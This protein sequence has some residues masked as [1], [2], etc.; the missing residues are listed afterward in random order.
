M[1][2]KANSVGIWMDHASAHLM[3][4][5]DET[6]E[7]KV[8][9]SKF[10]HEEKELTLTKGEKTMHHREQHDHTAYYKEIASQILQYEKVLLFGPTSAKTELLNLLRADHRFDKIDIETRPADKMTE[11]QQ[12]AFAKDYFH[13]HLSAI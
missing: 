11:N 1:T 3:E 8:I 10:T 13:K 9:D 4:I 12:H 6:V 7:T 5:S 2:M